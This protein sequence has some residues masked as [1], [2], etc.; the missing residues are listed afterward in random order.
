[1]DRPEITD[2]VRGE[3]ATLIN[4][5]PSLANTDQLA[6]HGLDSLRSVEVTLNLEDAFGLTFGDD[7]ISVENFA[8]I[9]TI[10]N[11]LDKRLNG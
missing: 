6:E 11:L 1:M 7:E 5:G 8:S 4:V 3:L 2:R 10:V 9:E